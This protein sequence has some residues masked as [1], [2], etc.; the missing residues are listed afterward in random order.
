MAV[1][2]VEFKRA[3]GHVVYKLADGTVVPGTTTICNLLDKPALG[4]WHNRKGLEGV[5]TTKY[6]DP[7][8]GV[9]TLTH[10]RILAEV[11]GKPLTEDLDEYS[12]REIDLSDNAMLKFYAWQKRH[13]MGEI[14][15]CEKPLVSEAYRFGGTPDHYG[16]IDGL[17]TLPDYKTGS[18]IYFESLLQVAAY[19]QLVQE[20]G[21]RVE[22]VLIVNIGR[23]EDE[24]FEE[25]EYPLRK[26]DKAWR[27]FLC[28]REIYDLKHELGG[29]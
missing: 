20:T 25:R 9:G 18:G 29:N 4:P 26:L 11:S 27:L 3:R 24:E 1:S 28:L 12:K 14:V 10:A 7:L 2:K 16:L 5:D 8:K 15:L 19:R 13:E 23:T 17:L 6:T 21:H 22:R